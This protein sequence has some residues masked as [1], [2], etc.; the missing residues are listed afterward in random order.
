METCFS[1]LLYIS[2]GR[3]VAMRSSSHKLRNSGCKSRYTYTHGTW[4]NMVMPSY[5]SYVESE[6]SMPHATSDPNGHIRN[7]ITPATLIHSIYTTQKKRKFGLFGLIFP[8][9]LYQRREC[10]NYVGG[11]RVRDHGHILTLPL[12]LISVWSSGSISPINIR[13]ILPN[14]PT[15]RSIR[16][17]YV[18]GHG[19]SMPLWRRGIGDSR[20]C[21]IRR[22]QNKTRKTN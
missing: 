2:D 6:N 21:W 11:I 19:C 7:E 4:P 12:T 18:K 22:L 9:N 5:G 8:S 10:P 3:N 20:P 15:Y 13:Y 17:T 1:I 16:S 14:Y